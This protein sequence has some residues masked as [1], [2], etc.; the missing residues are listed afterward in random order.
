MCALHPDADDQWITLVAR[1]AETVGGVATQLTAAPAA[2]GRGLFARSGTTDAAM[3][4]RTVRGRAK[5]PSLAT[6]GAGLLGGVV[7]GA[8]IAPLTAIASVKLPVAAAV[9]ADPVHQNGGGVRERVWPRAVRWPCGL[10]LL[11]DFAT[12][13]VSTSISSPGWQSSATHNA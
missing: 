13:V 12:G 11:A 4:A 2:A 10:E 8:P 1:V 6:A 7:L 5:P 3:T 9:G